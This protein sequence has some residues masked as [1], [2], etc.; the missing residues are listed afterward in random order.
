MSTTTQKEEMHPVFERIWEM[1]VFLAKLMAWIFREIGIG[2]SN[3][4]LHW[5]LCSGFAAVAGLSIATHVDYLLWKKAHLA[6][7]YPHWAPL[8][9]AYCVSF[10]GAGFLAWGLRRAIARKRLLG[11][12]KETFTNAGLKTKLDKFPAFISDFP[13]DEYTRKL[14][15]HTAGIPLQEFEKG[16]DAL[17]MGLHVYIDEMKADI[18]KGTIDILYSHYQMD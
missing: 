1:G 12:L 10:M 13:L 15:L 18:P 8:Y 9:W 14:R 6:K 7:L 4:T 17:Q 3:N 2:V 16:R 11:R 5:P